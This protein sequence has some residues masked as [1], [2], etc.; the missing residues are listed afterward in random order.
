M[1][2]FSLKGQ[3]HCLSYL[4][5]YGQNVWIKLGKLKTKVT[6]RKLLV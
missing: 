6:S 5:L 1:G 3:K 2:E 4:H